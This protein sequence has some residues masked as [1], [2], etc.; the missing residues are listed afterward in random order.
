MGRFVARTAFPVLRT[1]P[2]NIPFQVPFRQLQFAWRTQQPSPISLGAAICPVSPGHHHQ[3]LTATVRF[4]LRTAA[5]MQV[6][7]LNRILE[8]RHEDRPRAATFRF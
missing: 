4:D 8:V 2:G 1:I 7:L 6:Y 3:P 5:Q